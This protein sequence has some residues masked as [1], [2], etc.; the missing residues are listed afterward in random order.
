MRE[1]HLARLVASGTALD[2][3]GLIHRV[4][5]PSGPGSHRTVVML[6]GRSGDENAMWLFARTLPNSTNWLAAA[7]RGIKPDPDDGYAWHPRRRDEWPPLRMFDEAVAAVV[8]FIRAL[9][10]LYSADP[11][12]MYLMGFSQGAA[13]AY[14]TAMR[15]PGL[16]QGVAGIVGFVPGDCANV[17]RAA[18]LAGLPIFMAAGR[19]DPFIPLERAAACART[20]REGGALLDYHEYDA[21]HK[22]HAKGLQDL[23]RWWRQRA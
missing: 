5:Q 22:L 18:P 13:T 1:A 2:A 4:H 17:L 9:R 15:H 11:D 7:P 23:K 8:R 20:L 14:A 12:R 10:D 3:A 6:H 16:V 19:A 21:G